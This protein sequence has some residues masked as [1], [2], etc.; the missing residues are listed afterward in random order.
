MSRLRAFARRR[1]TPIM[2]G[3]SL[4]AGAIMVVL[5][6]GRRDEFHAALSGTALSVLVW[7]PRS[8]W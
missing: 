2:I 7:P 1:Q 8:T 4:L 3:G 6:A 5:L